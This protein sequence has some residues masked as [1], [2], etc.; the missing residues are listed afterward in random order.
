MIIRKATTKDKDIVLKWRNDLETR[1]NS[2][3]TKEISTENHEKWFRKKLE[4]KPTI[5]FIAEDNEPLAFVRIE[6]DNDQAEIHVN[7]NPE[8]RGKGIGK[9]SVRLASQE[10]FKHGTKEIIAKIKPENKN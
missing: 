5:M 4:S 1:N 9:E 3:N 10:E 6:R 2:F 7:V 8:K